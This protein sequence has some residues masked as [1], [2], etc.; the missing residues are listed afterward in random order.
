MPLQV[1][2]CCTDRK[3]TITLKEN[4]SLLHPFFEQLTPLNEQCP[5]TRINFALWRFL[6]KSLSLGMPLLK[7]QLCL[8]VGVSI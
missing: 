5:G 1:K 2:N 3:Y 7:C 8:L 4:I 6:I